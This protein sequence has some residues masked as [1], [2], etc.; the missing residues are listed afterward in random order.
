MWG[1]VPS[2]VCNHSKEEKKQTSASAHHLSVNCSREHQWSPNAYRTNAI[3]YI[4]L[5]KEVSECIWTR[6]QKK[7]GGSYTW[8]LIATPN[9]NALTLDVLESI[10]RESWKGVTNVALNQLCSPILWNASLLSTVCD[11]STAN[12]SVM[13]PFFHHIS[14]AGGKTRTR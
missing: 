2:M 14:L 4:H 9:W 5:E 1:L 3:A 6:L 12:S 10:W 7:S 8:T 13:A 11:Q